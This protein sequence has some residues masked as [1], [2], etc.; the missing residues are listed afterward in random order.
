M[1]PIILI[2]TPDVH[3]NNWGIELRW[4]SES[5][6]R[7]LKKWYGLDVEVVP[8]IPLDVWGMSPECW[9]YTHV[10]ERLAKVLEFQPFHQG[11]HHSLDDQCGRWHY[12]EFWGLSGSTGN[13]AA[14]ELQVT[15][16]IATLPHMVEEYRKERR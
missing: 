11:G 12:W 3:H 10:I 13:Q 4:P 6:A 5:D 16:F 1:T 14:K 2:K 7:M 9:D 8:D 15:D